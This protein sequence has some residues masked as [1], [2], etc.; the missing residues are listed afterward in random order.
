MFF[1]NWYVKLLWPFSQEKFSYPIFLNFNFVLALV[2]CLWVIFIAF[3]FLIEKKNILN[4]IKKL[5]PK[6]SLFDFK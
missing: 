5:L 6:K 3:K 2:G 4:E 1:T